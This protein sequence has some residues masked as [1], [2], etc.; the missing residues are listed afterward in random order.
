[1]VVMDTLYAHLHRSMATPFIWGQSDCM[2]DVADYLQ[3]LTGYDCATR[4]RGKYATA[5]ECQRLSGFLDDPIKP[6]ALCVGE[7]PLQ[8]TPNPARGDVG[9]V[10]I[11]DMRKTRSVGGIFLGKN[12]AVK[13]ENGLAIGQISK[14]LKAWKAPASA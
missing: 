6:F 5:L 7:F 4:Y 11:N 10:V 9:V 13:A 12:W 14:L 8:E 1:M 3:L 2:L